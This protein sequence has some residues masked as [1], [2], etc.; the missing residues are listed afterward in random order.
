MAGTATRVIV[1]VAEVAAEAYKA[2]FGQLGLLFDRAWLPL[3]IMLAATLVPGYLHS[4]VG[5]LDFPKWRNGAIGFSLED[6]IEALAGLLCLSAFAVRWYQTMLFPADH[7][8]PKSIFLGAWTRFLL[9]TLLL[10]FVSAILLSALI[11]ADAASL[12]TYLA[13]IAGVLALLIWVATVRCSLL[14]PAA[15]FGRPL[16]L[17]TAWRTMRGNSWRLLACGIVACAPV[18]LAII[19]ILGTVFSALHLNQDSGRLPLGFFILRALIGTCANFLVVAL[20][21][22]V[23]SAFYRRIM[24]RGVDA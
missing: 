1:P 20:G 6:V 15:A 14:F 12:P 24:L 18:I 13:P 9:Y 22:S 8:P 21:A 19:V 10:Y 5:W 16:G 4:Y 7:G 17:P 11:I 23:L 2:V 3:L